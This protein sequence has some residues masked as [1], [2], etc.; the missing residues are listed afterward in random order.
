MMFT[1]TFFFKFPPPTENTKIPSLDFKLQFLSQFEY[2]VS[3]PSSL[4]L[5]V[6]SETLSDGV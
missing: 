1:L 4:I 5:A 2:E 3:H 6:S